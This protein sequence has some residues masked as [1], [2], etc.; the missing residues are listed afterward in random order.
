MNK[1]WHIGH[2]LSKLRSLFKPKYSPE[3]FTDIIGASSLVSGDYKFNDGTLKVEGSLT[4]N[5]ELGSIDPLGS[6][7]VTKTGIVWANSINA[8]NLYIEGTVQAKSIRAKKIIVKAAATLVVNEGFYTELSVE[9]GGKMSGTL[10]QS[11]DP[12]H[13]VEP[14]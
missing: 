5:G 7:T 6:I 9:S 8:D 14:E 2:I 4:S 12:F 10:H 11:Q 3:V 13:V 1:Y